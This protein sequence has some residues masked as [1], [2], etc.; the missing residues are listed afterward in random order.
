MACHLWSGRRPAGAVETMEFVLDCWPAERR[1]EE[2]RK[3]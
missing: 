1:L 3:V 2:E